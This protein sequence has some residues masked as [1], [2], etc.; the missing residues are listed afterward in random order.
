MMLESSWDE[1]SPSWRWRARRL[2]ESYDVSAILPET[3]AG[4]ARMPEGTFI[5]L[6]EWPEGFTVSEWREL[7]GAM[8]SLARSLTV[9]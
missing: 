9:T 4:F 5:G 3:P 1:D 7:T 2:L 6:T 8:V